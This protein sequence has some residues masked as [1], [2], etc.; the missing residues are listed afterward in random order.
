MKITQITKCM[1]CCCRCVV[2][3]NEGTFDPS[4]L[5][6]HLAEGTN[7]TNMDG[8]LVLGTNV[9]DTQRITCN[10]TGSQLW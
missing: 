6:W 8:K 2:A 7:K 9:L 10:L 5:S 1:C 4:G 3:N